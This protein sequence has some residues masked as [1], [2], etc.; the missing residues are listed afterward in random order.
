[1]LSWS[2]NY[3]DNQQHHHYLKSLG[4]GF[5]LVRNNSKIAALGIAQSCFEGAMYTFV[6][7]WT[8]GMKTIEEIKAEEEGKIDELKE[9]T[10]D[11]L[12]LI[13]A[14][15]MVCVM[16]G[17]TIFRLTTN[18]KENIYLLPI[19]FHILA[20]VSMVISSLCVGTYPM[21][22]FLMFLLFEFCVGIYFPS[23]G[24]IKSEYIP[25]NVRASVM[26]IFRYG[27][28][29]FEKQSCITGMISNNYAVCY[30]VGYH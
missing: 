15:F 10:H 24:Y 22:V 30:T 17:S 26:N 23:Y 7:M 28:Y 8:N 12:G 27:V 2:D 4:L 25:E 20:C 3:G 29:L 18:K 1:M 6:F 21:I 5:Q 11:F 19:F 13:F 9:T 16:L 14:I